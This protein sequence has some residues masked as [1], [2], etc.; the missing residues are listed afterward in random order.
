MEVLVWNFRLRMQR[1]VWVAGNGIGLLHGQTTKRDSITSMEG[2]W[3]VYK[4]W[5]K[6]TGLHHQVYLGH[7]PKV[8]RD[9]VRDFNDLL[10][11][12]PPSLLLL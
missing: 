10:R 7:I 11:K 8:F 2:V 5:L 12:K 1:G 4:A 9:P 3:V 6:N